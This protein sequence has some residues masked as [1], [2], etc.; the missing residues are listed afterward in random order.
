[1]AFNRVA[2]RHIDQRNPRTVGR[3]IPSGRM[4]AAEAGWLVAISCAVFITSAGM[5]N[6]TA[7]MLSP[8]ALAVVLGYSFCKRFTW[9]AHL[10]LGLGLGVAPLGVW[11]ALTGEVVTPVIWLSLSV[12][13]WVAGFDILY[14]L[15]DMEF[16]RETRLQS[17]P[18]R[19]GPAGALWISRS[20]H[21]ITVLSAVAFGR[22]FGWSL[23][24]YAGVACMAALLF[25]EHSLVKKDDFSRIDQAFF[26]ANGYV[27]L[28]FG[29][30]AWL[31]LWLG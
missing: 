18:V 2:D 30:F 21:L 11:I 16:D 26:Q 19:F 10:V 27:S 15:Q 1:M 24:Y 7:L 22:A 25:W 14:S 17:V 4:K 6:T 9:G 23:W 5:C 20:L 13:S 31:D 3:P 8:V 12:M 28:L 29:G